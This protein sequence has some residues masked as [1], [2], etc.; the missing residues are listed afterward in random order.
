MKLI[1]GRTI[2][3]ER[4]HEEHEEER[5]RQGVNFSNI[6]RAAF[7]WVNPKSIKRY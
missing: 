7:A 4:C 1:L 3:R 6:L 5:R 2:C